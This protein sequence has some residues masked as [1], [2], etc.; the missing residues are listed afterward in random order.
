MPIITAP[1]SRNARNAQN[2][3]TSRRCRTAGYTAFSMRPDAEDVVQVPGMIV[4]SRE[5]S[6]HILRYGFS[7]A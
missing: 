4:F 1:A 6:P 5:I 3:S 7:N 2:V